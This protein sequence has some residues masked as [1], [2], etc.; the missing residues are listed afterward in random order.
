M[1]KHSVAEQEFEV[2][3]VTF[4][5]VCSGDMM[6]NDA[7]RP[8]PIPPEDVATFAVE[9]LMAGAGPDT[10]VVDVTDKG[11]ATQRFDVF[12][13]IANGSLTKG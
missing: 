6:F 9:R 8:I 13:W 7:T 4:D 10:F 5:C 3:F 12:R 2:T 1:S 11:G